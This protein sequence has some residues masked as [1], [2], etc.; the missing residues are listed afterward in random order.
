MTGAGDVAEVMATLG[1]ASIWIAMSGA[2]IMYNKFIL[3][4]LKFPFPLALTM[5]HMAFGSVA[6][7]VLIKLGYAKPE[8]KM[9]REVYLTSVLPIAALFSLVLWLGNAAYIYLS[10][11]FIQMT[12]ALM[13][14]IVFAVSIFFGLATMTLDKALNIAFIC[15]GVMVAAYGELR[16]DLTGFMLQL[17]SCFLEGLR[18]ALIQILLQKKGLKM[19]PITTLYYIAPACFLCLL[20]P[21]LIFDYPAMWPAGVPMVSQVISSELC[22]MMEL[23][24]VFMVRE[25]TQC[26]TGVSVAHSLSII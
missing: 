17:A 8:E 3:S 18:L 14:A 10:V 4:H 5:T 6:S 12:K 20:V 7:T 26:S 16:F 2:V 23:G 22:W 21:F 1:Y 19:N 24:G 11:S 25:S 15:F 13:P 9:T